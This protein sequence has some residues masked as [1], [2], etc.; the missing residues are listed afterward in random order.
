[1]IIINFD[2]FKSSL[3]NDFPDEINKPGKVFTYNFELRI[4]SEIACPVAIL[5]PVGHKIKLS[6]LWFILAPVGFD[7]L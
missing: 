2:I 3:N 5:I 4:G 1:M 7:G 6:C